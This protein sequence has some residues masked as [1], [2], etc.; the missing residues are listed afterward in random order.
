MLKTKR[1]HDDLIVKFGGHKQFVV[2]AAVCGMIHDAEEGLDRDSH[3][4]KDDLVRE[5]KSR[6]GDSS[7]ELLQLAVYGRVVLGIHPRDLTGVTGRL[8]HSDASLYRTI[9][10][11]YA[12]KVQKNNG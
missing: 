3:Q 9:C 4:F 12:K 2:S 8:S 6:V 10:V 5:V 11:E 1:K 7:S